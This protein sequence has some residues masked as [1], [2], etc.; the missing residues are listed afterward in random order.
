MALS[1]QQASVVDALGVTFST[2]LMRAAIRRLEL[3]GLSKAEISGEAEALLGTLRPAA[4][5]ALDRA[6]ADARVLVEGGTHQGWVGACFEAEALAA[7]VAAA[8]AWFA[9]LEV[10]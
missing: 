5:A 2:T 8:D 9:T 7:G 10:A 4:V 6:L 1:P 3:L